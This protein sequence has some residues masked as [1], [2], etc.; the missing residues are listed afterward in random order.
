MVSSNLIILEAL[1]TPV[2]RSTSKCPF[3][4]T[5]L[6]LVSESFMVVFVFHVLW[7]RK[8]VFF[9]KGKPNID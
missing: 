4:Y 9:F 7:K 8:C 1:K 5:V 2:K 3:R 6:T